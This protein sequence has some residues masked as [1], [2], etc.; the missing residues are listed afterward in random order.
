MLEIMHDAGWPIWLLLF[1]SV[2]GL[3]LIIERFLSLRKKLILPPDLLSQVMDMVRQGKDTPEALRLL[4]AD[5]ALGRI[6]AEVVAVNAEPQHL[7]QT[8]IE[9]AGADVSHRLNRYL[10]AL[11]TVAVVSPLLGLFGTVVGM[12]EIFGAYSP[13]GAD[14]SQLA[15]GISIALY[16]T[17]FGILIAIPA[18]IFHRYFRSRVEHFLHQM[19]RQASALN[20]ML[21]KEPPRR[22]G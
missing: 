7:R 18:L 14:P 17:G 12:I 13:S 16:N 20:R 4:A 8:A 3:A 10:P 6:L 22:Q 19:E 21:G 11:G 2:F 5:S 9:D 15:R 1:T